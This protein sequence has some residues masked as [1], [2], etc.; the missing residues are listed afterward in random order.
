M[1]MDSGVMEF[2]TF[3]PFFVYHQITEGYTWNE[4]F[5]GS[6]VGILFI[7]SR[8][9]IAA[10]VVEGFG[11]PA[12]AVMSTNSVYMTLLT[13]FVDNQPLSILE[14]MGLIS[15][16]LGSFVIAMGDSFVKRFKKESSITKVDI[17]QKEEVEIN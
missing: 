3:L 9:M 1:V 12:Q 7:Y 11:G 4:M 5:I 2:A 17:E 16:L 13:V 15:G 8:L 14:L 10:G 6:V